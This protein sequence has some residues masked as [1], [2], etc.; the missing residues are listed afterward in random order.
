MADIFALALT[1]P[2]ELI[3]FNPFG[4]ALF[5][6]FWLCLAFVLILFWK[7]PAFT[8]LRASMGKKL[9]LINPDLNRML[10]FRI[11]KPVGS[12]A[13]VKKR[14]FYILDPND[15]YIERGTKI[16]MALAFGEYG[17]TINPRATKFAER[18]KDLGIKNYTQLINFANAL[19]T[20]GQTASFK[21]L[22][23]TCSIDQVVDFFN[24]NERADY[25]EAE[26]QRRTA[27][28]TLQK[29]P[30]GPG[31][32]LKWIIIFGVFILVVAVAWAIIQQG[33]A[34]QITNAVN[35]AGRVIQPISQ[36]A[37][38]TTITP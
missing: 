14:G 21:L 3:I 29:L 24:R 9:L 19:K 22:G 30:H 34:S 11:A 27:S 13:Y 32:A 25:T 38:G 15:V 37:T 28:A 6:G 20:T 31:D 17:I 8:F 35:T 36:N 4:F 12:L 7:T 1:V 33:G 5:L 26:I 16:P 23:E 2:W 10:T 18:L